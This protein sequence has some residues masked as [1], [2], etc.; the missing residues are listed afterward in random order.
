MGM[1]G[2]TPERRPAQRFAGAATSSG[3]RY[4]CFHSENFA[5]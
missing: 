1:S 2:E 5:Q 4:S 3:K